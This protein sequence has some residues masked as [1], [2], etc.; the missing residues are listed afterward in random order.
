MRKEKKFLI[1]KK[2]AFFR[3][4]K[5]LDSWFEN[6]GTYLDSINKVHI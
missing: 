4:K 2:D 3:D 6:W 5:M 1:D